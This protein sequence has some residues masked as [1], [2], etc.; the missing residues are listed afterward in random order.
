[1]IQS[2]AGV[3]ALVGLPD[4]V[5]GVQALVDGEWWLYVETTADWA[6][7]PEC[8]CRAV[9]HGR[10]RSAV[11]DLPIA[12]RP[13]V[14]WFA[15]RRWRCPD[16]HCETNTWS[17]HCDSIAARA[18]LTCRARARIAD[19]V[20]IDG[21]TI[22]ATAAEFGVSWA[23]AN[24]AVVE[25]SDPIIEHPDRVG[26]VR[27][28][29]VDE[30]RFTNAKA[31]RSTTFTTQIVDLEHRQL[32][33]VVKGRPGVPLHTWLTQQGARWYSQITLATLDPAAGYRRALLDNLPN[34]TVVVDHFH[35]VRLANKAID[36]THRASHRFTDHTNYRRR[37]IA[38]YGIKWATVP[39]HR[40]QGRK[41]RTAA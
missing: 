4:L 23:T 38:R 6:A 2:S 31:G 15:R 7:C 10:G 13:T 9:G 21:W 40:T 34:A 25:F 39:T 35:P 11:R 5:V 27:A 30:K 8:G 36:D 3:T 22:T 41:P 32:L 26:G 33:D 37:L 24:S 18:S 19:L 20:N 14:L 29:G 28:I 16:P 17:E 1:M 12:G